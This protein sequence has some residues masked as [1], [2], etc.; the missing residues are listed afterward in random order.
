MRH[1]IARYAVMAAGALVAAA[2]T[3]PTRIEI[4]PKDIV[5]DAAG[6][7]V[8]LQAKVLDQNDE[9]MSTR[10]LDLAWYTEDTNVIHLTQ[11][12]VVSSVASGEAE[13]TVEVPGTELRAFTTVE[14]KIPSSV[15]VSVD[16]LRLWVGE[17]KQDI[18]ADVRTER[19]AVI[20]DL[21]PSFSSLD[22]DV[23]RVE[24]VSEGVG[25]R[26]QAKITG[27][28]PGV[29]RIKA[30]YETMS[31]E[32]KVT[33]FAE[34]EEVSMVGNHISKKKERDARRGKQKKEKALTYDF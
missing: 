8:L 23:V 3:T 25:V 31:T 29:A 22:P 2:C 17:S 34:D 12:G 13:V 1:A 4:T 28:I 11:D 6:K 19:G 9:V 21:R 32:I 30:G 10:G 20:A 7:T 24:P 27:I 33:V 14:V 18:W 16:K 5:L 26:S 15:Q